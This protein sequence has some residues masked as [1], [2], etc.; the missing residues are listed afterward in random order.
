VAATLPDAGRRRGGSR[1]LPRHVPV[2]PRARAGRGPLERRLSNRDGGRFRRPAESPGQPGAGEQ[3]GRASTRAG[4]PTRAEKR[5][6]T[7]D[8]PL[9]FQS[10][11][12]LHSV[13]LGL[14]S[15]GRGAAQPMD[16]QASSL[17]SGA[18]A[19]PARCSVKVKWRFRNPLRR[20]TTQVGAAAQPE[21]ATGNT[22]RLQSGRES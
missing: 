17:H 10:Q 20:R 1:G 11:S 8:P 16:K 2:D 13:T 5:E 15:S 18:F 4:N 14:L 21:L 3:P 9:R 22:S 19:S 7:G 6:R 12:C